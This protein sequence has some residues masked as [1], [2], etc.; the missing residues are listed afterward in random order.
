MSKEVK[1]AIIGLDTSHSIEFPRR[2]QAPD[3]ADYVKVEGMRAVSCLRFPTPFCDERALDEGQKKLE[4]WGIEVTTVFEEA[5]ADCDAIMLEINDPAPHLEY[6]KKCADLGKPIFLDK[7]LADTIENG[8][9]ICDLAKRKGL[10]V[11]SASSLRFVKALGECCDRM[12]NPM[13]AAMYGPVGP[14]PTG[15]SIVW[16]GVHAFEMLQRAMGRG[17]TGVFARKDKAGVVAVVD[18]EDDRRGIVELTE[19]GH[20]FGGCLRNSDTALPYVVD[21]RYAYSEQLREVARFFHGDEP[22]LSLEDTLEVMAM[23]DAAERSSQ[24]GKTEKV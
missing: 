21:M 20:S 6:F 8:R 4:G 15:S 17:A 7:P 19:K 13:F 12:P 23:L 22:P 1:V 2:M 10:R 5:V 18:Y 3:C 9:A 11:F 14:A 16:Y 24:S